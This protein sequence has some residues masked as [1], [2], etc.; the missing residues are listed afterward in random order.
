MKQE[1]SF[2]SFVRQRRR[3]MDLTQEELARRV[4]CAAITLRKIEADDL[5]PSVQ[6][7]ERLAMALG[8]PLDERA[9]FVRRARAIT[10]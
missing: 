6:I 8:I 9:E 3:E 10:P 1:S 5:R 4:G 2:G 7:A